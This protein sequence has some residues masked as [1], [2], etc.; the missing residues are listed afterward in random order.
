MITQIFG[1]AEPP[2]SWIEFE[3]GEPVLVTRTKL[4]VAVTSDDAVP[5]PIEPEGEP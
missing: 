5:P 3:D 2:E 4:K 1:I